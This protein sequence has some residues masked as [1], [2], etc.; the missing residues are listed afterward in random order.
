MIRPITLACA[1]VAAISGLYLYHVKHET[2][3]LERSITRT[4]QAIETARERAGVLRAEWTLMNDPERLAELAGQFLKLGTVSPRQFTTLA[5]LGGRLP[6]IRALPVRPDT[7]TDTPTADIP[8]AGNEVADPSAEAP[9]PLPPPAPPRAVM[10]T[11]VRPVTAPAT[12]TL[13]TLGPAITAPSAIAAAG[14]PAVRPQAPSP[15]APVA[16]A[17]APAPV[18]VRAVAP[19]PGQAGPFPVQR[20]QPIATTTV[21]QSAAAPPPARQVS[22][23]SALGMARGIVAPPVPVGGD[24]HLMRGN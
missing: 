2:Q 6:A 4:N 21:G 12:P 13:V 8:D 23:G 3:L 14:M 17:T 10:A 22:S 5:D 11:A 20:M 24:I 19:T 15:A 16:M 9:L 18:A 1:F 7:S